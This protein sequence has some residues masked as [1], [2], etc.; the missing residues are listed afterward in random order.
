MSDK[1][2]IDILQDYLKDTYS[3]KFYHCLYIRADNYAN[4]LTNRREI[5]VDLF[6]RILGVIDMNDHTEVY[7]NLC[8]YSRSVG[9]IQRDTF[10]DTLHKLKS[11]GGLY[12]FTTIVGEG[13]NSTLLVDANMSS[14]YKELLEY[15]IKTQEEGT[16]T[17][18][19]PM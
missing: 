17:I 8:M 18:D 10:E 1:L 2:D 14:E 15:L 19:H 4:I 5:T 13:D 7:D 12:M 6:K 16:T 3:D 9:G 11:L